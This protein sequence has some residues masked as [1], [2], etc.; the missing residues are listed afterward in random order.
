[1]NDIATDFS[2]FYDRAC[3]RKGG[4]SAMLARMPKVTPAGELKQ[5]DDRSIL[6]TITRC[7]FRAGFVWRIIEAKWPGFEEAFKG[8]VPLY[9]QQVPPEI[10]EELSKD[11]R[12][13]RNQQKINTVPANARMIVEVSEKYGSFGQFL[14]QWPSSQ[15]AELLHY[16]KKNGSRLGGVTPQYV[17][18]ELGWDGFILS[19]DVV[20]ALTNH[21]LIDASPTSQKGIKQAQSAFNSWHEQTQLP[22][23]HL[24]RILSYSVGD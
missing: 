22:Y 16:L 1:M 6:S 19:N 3:Q 9:W 20:T 4:E 18:R 24:S 17:L 15:Q 21:K 23:S 8:F 14:A 7:I 5:L 10:L 12:I 2:R 11:E 13:V